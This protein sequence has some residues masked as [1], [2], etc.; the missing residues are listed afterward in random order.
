MHAKPIGAKQFSVDTVDSMR[1]EMRRCD[2]SKRHF[3][4]TTEADLP[5]APFVD[6]DIKVEIDEAVAQRQAQTQTLIV[7]AMVAVFCDA[8][9]SGIANRTV[10]A[11]IFLSKVTP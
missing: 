8:S 2:P 4:E 1:N 11:V 9:S 6:I 7:E 3:Y 10:D 5:V